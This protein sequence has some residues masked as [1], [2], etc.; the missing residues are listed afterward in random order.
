MLVSPQ[1][2]CVSTAYPDIGLELARKIRVARDAASLSQV[3]LARHLG[4]AVRTL[5]A[6]EAGTMPQPRHRRLVLAFIA[7][8]EKAAA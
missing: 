3:E 7:E 5:Q 2:R 1:I 6:W 8:Q 4:V